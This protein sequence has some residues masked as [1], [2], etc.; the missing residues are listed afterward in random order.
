MGEKVKEQFFIFTDI[1]QELLI[2]LEVK[3]HSV[4]VPQTLCSFPFLVFSELPNITPHLSAVL[5][6][7]LHHLHMMNSHKWSFLKCM[8]RVK[9]VILLWP[10]IALQKLLYLVCHAFLCSLPQP[11]ASVSNLAKDFIQRLL[12]LDPATRLTADQ[13]IQHPWVVT[14]AAS[15]S[16]RNL[17]RS[18]SQN[19]RQRTSRSSMRCPSRST[20]SGGHSS[21]VPNGLMLPT[22]EE[23]RESHQQKCDLIP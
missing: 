18:I 17:H 21:V 5:T 10:M 12:L 23:C 3:Q 4:D 22:A 9:R 1:N 6:A 16:M 15:S 8:K 19:L 7:T 2:S 14:M 11:W 20:S 13:A